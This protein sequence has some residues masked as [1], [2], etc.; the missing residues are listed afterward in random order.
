MPAEGAAG[1]GRSRRQGAGEGGR[2]RAEERGNAAVVRGVDDDLGGLGLGL[3]AVRLA[4]LVD[5]TAR[6]ALA[7]PLVTIRVTE[8]E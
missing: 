2:Q 5:S 3:V 6:L 4:P 8:F 7:L 1:L